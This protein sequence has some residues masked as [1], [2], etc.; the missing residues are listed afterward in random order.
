VAGAYGGA[1]V[2]RMT[3]EGTDAAA[4]A[5]V[6]WGRRVLAR[7]LGSSRGQQ[8]GDAVTDL[9]ENLEDPAFTA[10]VFAQVRRALAEDPELAAQIAEVRAETSA[11]KFAVTVTA[12]TGVHVGDHNTQTITLVEKPDQPRSGR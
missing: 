6:S 8:I 10:A 2:Q 12:S 9:G 4:D 5:T 11:G 7:L 3:D 1:V